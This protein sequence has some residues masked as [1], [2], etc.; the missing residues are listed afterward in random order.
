MKL[1]SLNL[2]KIASES[3]SIRSGDALQ[4]CVDI[5]TGETWS[6]YIVGGTSWIAYNNTDIITVDF[7]K[8]QITIKKLKM[9]VNMAI[10]DR[11]E[12]LCIADSLY[13]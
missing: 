4:V 9:L 10:V 8:N 12:E 6:N 13:N 3:K 11:L 1:N 2:K 5:R 7:L